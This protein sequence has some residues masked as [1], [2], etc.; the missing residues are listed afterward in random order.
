MR[1][2]VFR[3]LVWETQF[4]H[5]NASDYKD[6]E[7]GAYSDL[8]AGS[9]VH[10]NKF[11]GVGYEASTLYAYCGD[12]VVPVFCRMFPGNKTEVDCFRQTVEAY[13]ETGSHLPL[14]V[15]GDSGGYS[16]ANLAYLARRGVVP[17]VN[18]RENITSQPVKQFGDH[19]FFNTKYLPRAVDRTMTCGRVRRPNG[20]GTVLFTG[21]GGLQREAR[22][23][24]GH[25]RRHEAPVGRPDLRRAEDP[26]HYKAGRPDLFHRPTVFART[27]FAFLAGITR[28]LYAAE[29]Y[30]PLPGFEAGGQFGS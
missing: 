25:C 5:S 19:M 20:D 27:R 28:A 13:F 14:V 11:L 9:S 29:G 3:I 8:D 7:T 1:I 2:V 6:K 16:A 17:L 24:S 15:I 21:S 12:R 26:R 4:V 23:Y 30:H 10:E 22:E 18:A